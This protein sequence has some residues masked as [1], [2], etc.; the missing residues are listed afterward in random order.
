MAKAFQLEQRSFVVDRMPEVLLIE[1]PVVVVVAYLVVVASVAV[2]AYL[3]LV[4]L[5]SNPAFI[6]AFV[7]VAV[8]LSIVLVL[9]FDCC[10]VFCF[11][12][13]LV[14][15]HLFVLSHFGFA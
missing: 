5:A 2:V 15:R 9:V 7:A 12:V 3:A 14:Y 6:V 11:V 8:D 1:E 4:V 13:D 10:M